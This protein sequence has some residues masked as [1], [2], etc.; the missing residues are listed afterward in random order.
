[1]STDIVGI[2]DGLRGTAE[3]VGTSDADAAF[4]HEAADLIATLKVE[5][6]DAWESRDD[7]KQDAAATILSMHAD[8]A[9]LREGIATVSRMVTEIATTLGVPES[10]REEL[11]IT[12]EVARALLPKDTP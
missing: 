3:N 2:I 4:F 7:I 10:V 1:M 9:K 6:D 11:E 5:R 12:A 8:I